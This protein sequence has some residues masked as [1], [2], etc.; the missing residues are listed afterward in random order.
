MSG[1]QA[2]AAVQVSGTVERFNSAWQPSTPPE[3]LRRAVT[4]DAPAIHALIT[5]YQHEGRLLPRTE[6]EIGRHAARFLVVAEGDD[7][8]GCAELAPL[9]GVVAEVRS[10]VV[11]RAARGLG[12]GQRLV[13]AIA[14]DASGLGFRT[15]CAFTHEPGYFARLGFSMVPHAWLPEKI[16]LDCASCVLFRR[17]GQSAMRLQLDEHRRLRS[18]ARRRA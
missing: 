6:E 9:S 5:R 10:L 7:V 17:C 16:G 18:Q 15:V 1:L 11:D 12:L 2:S 13:D 8:L 4:A 14:D 3:V